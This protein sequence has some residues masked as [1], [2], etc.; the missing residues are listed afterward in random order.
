VKKSI[1]TLFVLL[2]AVATAVPADHPR[3]MKFEPLAFDPPEP[4]RFE[5][6]SGLVVYFLED[7]QLP[8]LTFRAFFHGS[9]AYDPP[10]KAGLI[11]LTAGLLRRGGAG[12]RSPEQIDQDLDFVGA[13]IGSNASYDDITADMNCLVK[14]ADFCFGILSDILMRPKFDS[15]KLELDK[16][17]RK[18]YIRRQNDDAAELSRR[19]YYQTVYTGHP[20]SIY[21]TLASTDN[22]TRDDIIAAHKRFYH[23]DNCIMAIAGDMT[24]DEVKGYINKYFASWPKSGRQIEPIA[25]ADPQYTPGVYYAEKDVNQAIIRMGHLSLDDRNPDRFAF[26]IMNFALGGGG[27]VS[28]MTGRVRTSAGLAYS[29]GT[30]QYTRPLMGTFFGYCYTSA[31]QM[32]RATQMMIDIIAE[33][34]TDGITAEEMELARESIINSYIF[35]YDTPSEIVNA[36]AE[37]EF[38]GFPPDHL[39]RVLEAYQQVT[40][41]DCTF[42]AKKYLDPDNMVIVITGNKALFDKPPGLFGPVVDVPMEIK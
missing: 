29:V 12:D 26:D 38:L 23:P 24:L 4:A 1:L 16:S 40:L 11:S 6:S 14:D 5:T 31:G 21:P 20:Y 3:N 33:V 34:K 36:R 25:P 22:I 19:V 7:H 28:R 2:L 18:D 15:A 17:N 32:A 30:Y 10:G 13:S 41:D 39:R 27:F 9:S 8:V 42:V 35:D 37:V